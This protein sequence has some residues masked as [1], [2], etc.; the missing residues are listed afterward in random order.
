MSTGGVTNDG[1]I[2]GRVTANARFSQMRFPVFVKR[3]LTWSVRRCT[4]DAPPLR[5]RDS[6]HDGP[7]SGEHS[8]DTLDAS[9]ECQADFRGFEIRVDGSPLGVA[10]VVSFAVVVFRWD[11]PGP[12]S[13]RR[14]AVTVDP[15]AQGAAVG[16]PSSAARGGC[17]GLPA[18]APAALLLCYR[19]GSSASLSACFQWLCR[20][21]QERTAREAA[22]RR[23][24]DFSPPPAPPI[25]QEQEVAGMAAPAG[26]DRG[27]DE[28]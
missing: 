4:S 23:I 9:L 21:K 1:T 18:A 15:A 19:R 14:R 2:A 13:G 11:C 3:Q 5:S 12:R 17:S 22:S 27:P 10:G 7:R 20:R 26:G 24:K 28:A 8:Y 6:R 25:L 16:P